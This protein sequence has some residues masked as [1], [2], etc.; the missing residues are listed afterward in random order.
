MV[1]VVDTFSEEIFMKLRGILPPTAIELF[2]RINDQQRTLERAMN[3]QHTMMGKIIEAMKLN[4]ELYKGMKARLTAFDKR[5]GDTTRD[6]IKS[7]EI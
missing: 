4:Q 3:E 6:Q 2:I 1:D 5:Y 7:E